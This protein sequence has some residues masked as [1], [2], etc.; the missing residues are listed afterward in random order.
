MLAR[1]RTNYRVKE[2]KEKCWRLKKDGVNLMMIK[3]SNHRSK[4]DY[5]SYESLQEQEPEEFT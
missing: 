4:V 3:V 1:K 5:L 2:L